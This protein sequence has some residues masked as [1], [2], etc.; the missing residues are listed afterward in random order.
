[1]LMTPNERRALACALNPRLRPA[2]DGDPA[3][4]R[5]LVNRTPINALPALVRDAFDFNMPPAAFREVLGLAWHSKHREVRKEARTRDRLRSWFAHANFPPLNTPTVTLW[6]GAALIAGLVDADKVAS[7]ASWTNCRTIGC[8]FAMGA[9]EIA[10]NVFGDAY[11]VAPLVIRA[12]VRRDHVTAFIG[13][14]SSEA[15]LLDPPDHYVI[16]GDPEDWR[17]AA[18]RARIGSSGHG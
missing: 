5:A 6:R 1:M 2:L 7:G 17:E 16:D 10:R 4:A 9:T 12:E 8:Y 18:V 13:G 15:V 11:A 14:P 3:A